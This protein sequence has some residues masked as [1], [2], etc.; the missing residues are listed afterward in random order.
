[1]SRTVIT[2]AAL[3]LC[4]ACAKNTPP[5]ETPAGPGEPSSSHADPD[6]LP[7]PVDDSALDES[8]ETPET[9]D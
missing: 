2:L 5:P 9:K 3:T 1:M 7:E 6:S 4:A 8:D